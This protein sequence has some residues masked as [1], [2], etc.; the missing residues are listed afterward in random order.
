MY[1]MKAIKGLL[2]F[3]ILVLTVGACFDPPEFGL[4]PE[5]EYE[6]I[7]FREA[8]GVGEKDSLV[9]TISFRD[10][11]G[12]LGL[13]STQIDEPYN[14]ENFYLANNGTIT[15]IGKITKYLNLPQFL[16]IPPGATGKLVSVRTSDDPEY[17]SVVLPYIDATT[18]CTYYTYT[19][20][21]V[22]EGDIGIFD[23]TYNIDTVLMVQGFPKVYVLL[24]TF[25]YQRNPDY[26]NIDVEFWIKEGGGYQLFDWEKEFCTISFNQRFPVLTEKTGPLEGDLQYAMV[27]SG[28]KSLFSIKTM[29]LR[30][31]IR[32]RSLNVSNVIETPE[33]TLEKIRKQ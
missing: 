28:I 10:G 33:F 20:A 32:D 22:S 31:R 29:K 14:D 21:Y 1:G 23:D 6:N 19:E 5:I 17:T 27:T 25:Y 24:D 30:I 16:S 11:N 4:T 7:Y 9:L 12:D 15:P 18:S 26:A 8:K 13:S 2:L 3:G